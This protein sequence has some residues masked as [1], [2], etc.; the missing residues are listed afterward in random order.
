V[1]TDYYGRRTKKNKAIRIDRDFNGKIR[2]IGNVFIN[3]DFQGNVTRIGS[4]FI[5]YHRGLLTK[6]GNLRVQY[7]RW[8]NPI[9]RGNVKHTNHYNSY[10]TCPSN[11]YNNADVDINIHIYDYNDHLFYRKNFRNNYRQFKED[12]HYYYYRATPNARIGKGSRILKR[13]KHN[14]KK[15]EYY[16]K[17]NSNKKRSRR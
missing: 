7:D 1:Y 4:V 13:R 15:Q 2:R 5:N 9:Y 3:Y 6:V 14:P 8:G 11:N 12:R 16:Y 17:N 10:E